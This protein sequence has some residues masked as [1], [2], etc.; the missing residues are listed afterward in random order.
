M[1]THTFLALALGMTF[2][3]PLAAQ[4]QGPG[5]HRPGM[6]QGRGGGSLFLRGLDLTETQKARLKVIADK[7]REGMKSKFEAAAAAH[8]DLRTAM[9][10]PATSV[11]Q[12]KALHDKVAKAQFEL[13]LDRRAMRQES[14]ALLTP[15]QKAKAEE[16]RSEREARRAD[17]PRGPGAGPRHGMG[18]GQGFGPDCPPLEKK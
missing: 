14:L 8:K 2:V 5:S 17:H 12:L 1:I 15:E 16:L 6:A 18:R 7:H 9:M 10:D 3:A 13:A 11:E 4:G